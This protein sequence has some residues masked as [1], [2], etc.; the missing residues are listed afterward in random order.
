MSPYISWDGS[1]VRGLM[2]RTPEMADTSLDKLMV[3]VFSPIVLISLAV[4]MSGLLLSACLA[5]YNRF[6]SL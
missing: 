5:L 1:A 3:V 6:H 2:T 4:F